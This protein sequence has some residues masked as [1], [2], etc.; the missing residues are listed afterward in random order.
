MKPSLSILDNSFRYIRADATSVADTWR[1]F[2]WR[3][4]AERRREQRV[5]LRHR[6]LLQ[7][8]TDA[9]DCLSAADQQRVVAQYLEAFAA[10]RPS[11]N[12][13]SRTRT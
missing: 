4:R 3:S 2:G 7:S 13:R 12:A 6:R 11:D 1:R 9:F 5:E 8:E 10:E